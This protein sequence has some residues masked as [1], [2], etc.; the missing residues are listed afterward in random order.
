MEVVN[1]VSSF[2]SG[3]TQRVKVDDFFS[4]WVNVSSGIPQGSVL[5][6]LLFVVFINDLPDQ[7][8]YSICKMFTDD[9]KISS[10]NQ[11]NVNK[12]QVDLTN[13]ERWSKKWQLP[14][15]PSKCKVMHFGKKNPKTTSCCMIVS[16]ILLHKK[17]IWVL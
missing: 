1:W 3:R 12:L 2:L 5:G 11:K 10:L 16:W 15:N 8:K 14:F 7:L 6:P 4:K 17:R 13:L 9:C